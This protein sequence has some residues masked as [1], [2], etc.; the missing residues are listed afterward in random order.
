[1]AGSTAALLADRWSNEAFASYYGESVAEGAQG[2]GDDERADRRAERSRPSRSTRGA[3]SGREVAAIEDY[4]YAASLALA[5]AIAE[6]AG[7]D[8]LRAV[9]QDAA[10]RVGAYQPPIAASATTATA[11]PEL[12]AGPPDWRGPARPA[13][14]P[15]RR[16]RTTTCGG[17]G[18]PARRTCRCSTIGPPPG[19]PTTRSSRRPA[20][21]SCRGRSAMRC[22]PGGSTRPRRSS[23]TPTVV[24]DRRAEIEAAAEDAGLVAAGD[25]AG[26][27]P[28]HGRLRR[29]HRRGDR[30]DRPRS[31]AT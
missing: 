19:S 13:R 1:M 30:R 28:G 26:H 15:R 18:S 31:S 9:W 27:V 14:G 22:G 25:A 2:Q 24:L 6:R 17:R 23:T 29:C 10:D 21:G 3:R 8:G 11:E 12:V 4:G 5:R 7:T 20:T 16:R